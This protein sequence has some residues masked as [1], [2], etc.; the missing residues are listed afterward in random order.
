MDTQP[1][2]LDTQT[3]HCPKPHFWRKKHDKKPIHFFEKHKKKLLFHTKSTKKTLI[4]YEKQK[5]TLIF[6]R[7]TKKKR[8][9]TKKKRRNLNHHPFPIQKHILLH[10]LD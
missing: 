9:K 8:K 5:K 6:I 7:K 1:P 3:F 10:F 2:F 4:S